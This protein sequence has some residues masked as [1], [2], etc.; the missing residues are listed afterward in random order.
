MAQ[1]PLQAFQ[2]LA[3]GRD[4][5][6]TELVQPPQVVGDVGLFTSQILMGFRQSGQVRRKQPVGVVALQLLAGAAG[7]RVDAVV[8]RR[9]GQG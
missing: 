2:Q 3:F 4:L 1:N 8:Q 5:A 9:A 6:I 7:Q